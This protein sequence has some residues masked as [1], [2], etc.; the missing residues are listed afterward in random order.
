MV[1]VNWW[2]CLG[3]APGEFLV[4]PASPCLIRTFLRHTS[5]MGFPELLDS[6]RPADRSVE[7]ARW[8]GLSGSYEREGHNS[9]R[10]LEVPHSRSTIWSER[11]R[12]KARSSLPSLSGTLSFNIARWT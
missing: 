2:K 3:L 11:L 6:L 9:A 12:N 7:S 10:C 4:N 5:T 8:A 1:P